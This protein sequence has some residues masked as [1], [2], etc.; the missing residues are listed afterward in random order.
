MTLIGRD[1]AREIALQ[2]EPL[3]VRCEFCATVY[4]LPADEVGALFPDA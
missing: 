1:E 2:G 4:R 3:E